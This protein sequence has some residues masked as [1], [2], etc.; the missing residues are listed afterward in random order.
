MLFRLAT[1]RWRGVCITGKKKDKLTR[2]GYLAVNKTPDRKA[3][4]FTFPINK[5]IR[6]IEVAVKRAEGMNRLL[7]S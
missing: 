5:N 4:R 6:F 2:S 7:L 3:K 1:V